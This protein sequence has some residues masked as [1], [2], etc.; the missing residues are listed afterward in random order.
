MALWLKHEHVSAA[1]RVWV[2]ICVCFAFVW[3]CAKSSGNW[4]L[5]CY[6]HC[7]LFVFA[8]VYI[9]ETNTNK[10]QKLSDYG[11]LRLPQN[12]ASVGPNVPVFHIAPNQQLCERENPFCNFATIRDSG[13]IS[14]DI[15]IC[16]LRYTH[17]F[18]TKFV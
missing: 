7:Q 11:D 4:F 9:I 14:E 3:V 2:R 10:V 12:E 5:A 8:V 17:L 13:F 15:Q 1:V 18:P 16:S 6:F